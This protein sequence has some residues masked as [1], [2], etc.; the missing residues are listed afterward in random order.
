[1]CVDDVNGD[2]KLDLLVGDCVSLVH[3]AKGV[4]PAVAAG[5]LRDWEAKAA[6]LSSKRPVEGTK[7]AEAAMK[8]YEDDYADLRK[9]R[10]K[11]VTDERTG[12][13]WVLYQ[14]SVGPQTGN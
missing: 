12:F 10:E 5:K 14:K 8:K 11:F 2:G 1:V 7:G 4:A 6:E 3:P 13:V 9:E